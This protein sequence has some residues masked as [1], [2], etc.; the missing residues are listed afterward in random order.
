MGVFESAIQNRQ[1]INQKIQDNLDEAFKE[2]ELLNKKL[3][4]FYNLYFLHV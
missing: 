1:N 3:T 4:I 2:E